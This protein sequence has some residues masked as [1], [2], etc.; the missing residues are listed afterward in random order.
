MEA[1]LRFEKHELCI[2]HQDGHVAFIVLTDDGKQLDFGI[3]LDD[4]DLLK[5]YIDSSIRNWTRETKAT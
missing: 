4:W 5:D 1:V 2:D 3:D